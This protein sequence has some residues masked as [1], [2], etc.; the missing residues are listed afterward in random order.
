MVRHLAE[1]VFDFRAYM[2]RCDE[3]LGAT[4]GIPGIL[5]IP[6]IPGMGT[7]STSWGTTSS[8]LTFGGHGSRR[9]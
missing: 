4:P 5:G 6:G 3:V 1:E 2:I 9:F 7:F 8:Q